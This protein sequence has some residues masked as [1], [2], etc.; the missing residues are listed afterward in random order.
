MER[1][2]IIL[3]VEELTIMVVILA[4]IVLLRIK[5]PKY[6]QK[7]AETTM[8]GAVLAKVSEISE[9]YENGLKELSK[10]IETQTQVI[11]ATT[12]QTL[13]NMVYNENIP[14]H[15][16]LLAFRNYLAMGGN[17]N[18]KEFAFPM[19]L[20]K[21]LFWQDITNDRE[22]YMITDPEGYEKSLNDIKRLI[23]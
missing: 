18:C 11:Q 10:A 23:L 22:G 17:G 7:K 19:V 1:W 13:E 20:E 5:L 3:G 8:T 15:K 12:K 4:A 2:G 21:R 14:I 9:R 6:I 16:R